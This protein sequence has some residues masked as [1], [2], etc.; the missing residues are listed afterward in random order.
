MSEFGVQP[1]TDLRLGGAVGDA[2]LPARI[3]LTPLRVS[4]SLRVS[5]VPAR[6]LSARIGGRGG[7]WPLNSGTDSVRS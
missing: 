4:A 5:A 2:H 7:P 1:L 3:E 6:A